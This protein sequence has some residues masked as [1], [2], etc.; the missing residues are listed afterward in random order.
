[1]VY[2]PVKKHL[3]PF[4]CV[5]CVEVIAADIAIVGM[6]SELE[7]NFLLGRVENFHIKIL[8]RNFDVF[9]E[10]G[11]LKMS[12]EDSSRAESQR[13]IL[14]TEIN[15]G[16]IPT[17]V[18]ASGSHSNLGFAYTSDDTAF[19]PSGNRQ[20]VSSGIRRSTRTSSGTLENG[21][22]LFNANHRFVLSR[23]SFFPSTSF[24]PRTF[25]PVSSFPM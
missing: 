19:R 20:S 24:R 21:F 4:R 12:L 11:I 9:I 5:C 15:E 8:V 3:N 18:R 10:I 16:A 17:I 14:H 23:A 13:Y 6:H 7:N 1:M 2:K 22:T 25:I